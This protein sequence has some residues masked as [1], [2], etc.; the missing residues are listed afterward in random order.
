VTAALIHKEIVQEFPRAGIE[1]QKRPNDAHNEAG[2]AAIGALTPAPS[3]VETAGS[4]TFGVTQVVGQ[5]DVPGVVCVH[6]QAEPGPSCFAWSAISIRLRAALAMPFTGE[7]QL[8]PSEFGAPAQ[9]CHCGNGTPLG[10]SVRDDQRRSDGDG[11]GTDVRPRR[12]DLTNCGKLL[13]SVTSAG[14]KLLMASM[15]LEVEG[16]VGRWRECADGDEAPGDAVV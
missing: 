3:K 1:R 4:R 5:T 13:V 7:Y 10:E 12:F 11:S 6:A 15:Q 14:R 8:F 9:G 16:G 2:T